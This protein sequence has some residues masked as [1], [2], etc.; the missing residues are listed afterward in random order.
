MKNRL[1]AI[2]ALTAVSAIWGVAGPV[3]KFGLDY[4]PPFTFLFLRFLI[5]A[6]IFLPFFVKEERK[7]PIH[8]S[9]YPNLIWIGL[10]GMTLNLGLIFLGFERTSSIEG[11]I[12]TSS[13]PIMIV[14]AGWLFLKEKINRLEKTGIAVAFVGTLFV[15]A[16]PFF[17]GNGESPVN[18]SGLTGNLLILLS[19]FAFVGYTLVSRKVT[20]K[21]SAMTLT[22]TS[23]IIG[24]LSFLPLS[25]YEVF[26][27]NRIPFF[28]G[29]SVTS[30]IYMSL[31]SLAAA[32]FLYEWSLRYV[33]ASEAG[34]FAYLQPIFMFP[35]AYFILNERITPL[36][37]PGILIAGIGVVIATAGSFKKLPDHLQLKIFRLTIFGKVF[38]SLGKSALI[39]LKRP[40]F[41]GRSPKT[42]R[43][44]RL[45]SLV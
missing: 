8:E 42:R 17:R 20:K 26:I 1:P 14:L 2:I 31:L 3:I 43:H 27:E 34:V 9:D 7:K 12:I 33:E 32:Y 37:W 40:I 41:P 4:I 44:R 36:L 29:E 24:L 39:K 23:V 15:T 13:T 28:T 38:S 21:Y 19:N 6:F 25:L 5:V 35:A 11:T 30:L 10:L 22:F 16:E 45:K 18:F